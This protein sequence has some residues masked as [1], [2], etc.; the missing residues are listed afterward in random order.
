M[1]A[2][3]ASGATPG[4]A[5]GGSRYRPEIDGL[6]ALAVLPVMLFHA[7]FDA[8]SG[9]YVGVDVFF[10]ISGFLITTII[11]EDC[12]AGRFSIVRFY[13]RR[14]RRLLPAL[15]LV[16]AAGIPFAWTWML[17][18][19]LADF[20]GSLIAV[21]FFVSNVLFWHTGG[22]FDL[23]AEAKPLLHTWSLGVEEQFYFVF[24]LVIA[25]G[26]R[27]G[28]RRLTLGLGIVAVLSLVASTWLLDRDALAAFFLLPTR[29]WELLAGAL[30]A[31]V[32]GSKGV[33]TTAPVLHNALALVGIAAILVAV[34]AYDETTRIPGVAALLPVSGT[35]LVLA[36]AS[37][38][39]IAGR[40][41][42]LPPVL[43]LGAISYSAY[44]WHQPLYAF[45]RLML[46][47]Q[48]SP[49]LFGLLL[50]AALGL[51]H[52]S[53]RFVEV[54]FRDGSRV[55]RRA[56]LGFALAGSLLLLVVGCALVSARGVPQRFSSSALPLLNRGAA[57][58]GCPAI[59]AW[60][61]V[62]R[63]GDPRAS[64][65]VVLLGDSHAYALRPALDDALKSARRGGYAVHTTCHPV[66]GLFNSLEAITP[67]RIAFCAEANRRLLAF[68]E[69]PQ[70]RSVIVAV[71]WT[72]RLYPL[73]GA[74]DAPAFNN[75]EGGVEADALF[76]RNLTVDGTG[77]PTA[78]AQPKAQALTA[79]LTTLARRPTVVIY[80]IP[81]V[82]WTPQRVNLVAVAR[83]NP[84][85]TTIS[86]S[87]A[88][89]LS[90]NAAAIR[91]L[92]GISAPELRRSD[93]S[94]ILCNTRL[95]DRCIV[96]ADGTLYYVD[97]DHL[98]LPAA[99]LVVTD[100]LHRL[101]R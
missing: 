46:V 79:Y 56:N 71:R 92:N 19:E 31:L 64:A 4:H 11:A 81:E 42:A 2:A 84:P 72:L 21:V 44:L 97:D 65:S 80:P 33:R 67:A 10:V 48:P 26:W 53:Y 12:A 57:I 86:T 38:T 98:G 55:S 8:F 91:M 76:R 15:F 23:A 5:P 82:G 36:F 70:V 29:A 17:P 27:F 41:L 62:C 16:I 68:V 25:L 24:P 28:V 75:G 18:I 77:E 35:L 101:E 30:L 7:G 52:L 54:P 83:G 9:G 93:P 3:A 85:P 61:N 14:A 59:D 37:R 87:A 1:N 22:Y 78:A 90:R 32:V 96:Q 51:A 74:I 94:R 60:L 49:W 6:R 13:E 73:D 40:L 50:V 20:G 39:S 99:R 100:A 95:P 63:I 66:P 58:E 88:R 69:R 34:F 45:A 43:W 47:D 89:Y